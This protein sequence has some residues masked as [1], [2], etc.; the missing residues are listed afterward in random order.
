MQAGRYRTAVVLCI[1]LAGFAVA[2][3]M[4]LKG[5]HENAFTFLVGIFLLIAV[6]TLFGGGR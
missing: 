1:Y 6:S 4:F 5:D 2:L 3:R